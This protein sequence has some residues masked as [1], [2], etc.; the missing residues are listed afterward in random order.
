M[1]Y[2][3]LN[4]IKVTGI[5]PSRLHHIDYFNNIVLAPKMKMFYILSINT[6]MELQV[7][8]N[9][10]SSPKNFGPEYKCRFFFQKL[11]RYTEV[12]YIKVFCAR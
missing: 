11:Y 5:F 8:L 4:F 6:T 9:I 1:N 10:D 7:N 2:S 3:N 12:T